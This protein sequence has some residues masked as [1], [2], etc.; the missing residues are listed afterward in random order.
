MRKWT[1]IVAGLLLTGALTSE[2]FAASVGGYYRNDGT[3]VQ[4]YQ[5]TNPDG[6]PFNNYSFPGNDN[7]NIGR[8]TPGD[9]QRYLDRY[10]GHHSGFGG[11]GTSQNPFDR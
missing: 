3:Y 7:P 1:A 10:Y 2:V 5:R 9:Q 11:F 8:T 4:P 6:N